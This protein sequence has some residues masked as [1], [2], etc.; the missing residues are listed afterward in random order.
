MEGSSGDSTEH[1]RCLENG[2]IMTITKINDTTVIDI[3]TQ[4]V[5][6]IYGKTALVERKERL[7]A[8]LQKI[9]DLLAALN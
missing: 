7:G 2:I 5:R 6:K 1:R 4:E 3:G 9:N 8:E